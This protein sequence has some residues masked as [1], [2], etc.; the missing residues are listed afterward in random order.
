MTTAA[1]YKG[2][3][4]ALIWMREQDPPCPWNADMAAAAAFGGHLD[5]LKWVRAQDPPCPWNWMTV[6]AARGDY[7]Q[8][9]LLN[10]ALENGCP[11]IGVSI[12]F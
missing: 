6:A 2:R 10:W 7:G 1:A 8:N 5:V 3:L 12:S 9:E 4:E 11:G